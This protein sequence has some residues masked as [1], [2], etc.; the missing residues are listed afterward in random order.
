MRCRYTYRPIAMWWIFKRNSLIYC[1]KRGH[2]EDARARIPHLD[3]EEITIQYSSYY[4]TA[5]RSV[6]LFWSVDPYGREI[7]APRTG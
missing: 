7:G 4:Y 1:R 2:L 6:E 3:D 5:I